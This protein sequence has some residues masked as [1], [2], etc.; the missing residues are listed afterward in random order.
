MYKTRKVTDL[1]LI[2]APTDTIMG[3]KLPT[4]LQVLK[5]FYYFHNTKKQSINRSAIITIDMATVFW[6]KARIPIRQKCN[7][8]KK[9]KML[10]INYDNIKKSKNRRTS[11]QINNEAKFTEQ[12]NKLFDIAHENSLEMINLQEDKD[13]LL[14]QRSG[15]KGQ[16]AGIDHN[17]TMKEIRTQHRI[18]KE[19]IRVTKNKIRQLKDQQNVDVYSSSDDTEMSVEETSVEKFPEKD[20]NITSSSHNK[21]NFKNIV[22]PQLTSALDRAKVTDRQAV[23]VV[24]AT[25]SSLGNNID[26]FTLSRSSIRRSRINHRQTIAIEN[27]TK[28]YLSNDPVI[29]HWDGKLLPELTGKG[30]CDRLPILISGL[31]IE[32]LLSVPKIENGTGQKMSNAIIEAIQEWKISDNVCGMSFDTTASNTGRTSGACVLLEQQI[33]KHLLNFACR[34]HIFEIILENVF[35]ITMGVSSGPDIQIF[36]RFQKCWDKIDTSMLKTGVNDDTFKS[37]LPDNTLDEVL[38]F[39]MHHLTQLHP[40]EDYRELLNL[41]VIFLGGTPPGGIRLRAPAGLHRARWMAR[42]LYSFKI[43]MF[44]R[45]KNEIGT[46]KITKQEE[47]GIRE[48]L[49]F[50]I[51]GGYIQ[52][53]ITAPFSA[54]APKN[55]LIFL[56]KLNKYKEINK[57]VADGAIKKFLGHLW[58]LS[59]DLVGLAF[60]DENISIIEKENMVLALKTKERSKN[61]ATRACITMYQANESNLLLSNFITKRTYNFFQA[62]RLNMAFLESPPIQWKCDSNYIRALKVVNAIKVVN[63]TAERGVALISEYND[64]LT[65]DELQK[66][67]LLQVIRE[68]RKKFPNT[69]KSTVA[70]GLN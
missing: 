6:H 1:F 25:V 38:Q 18:E 52:A 46:F 45:T 40:R 24:A 22:T 4:T 12:F 60:F 39:C 17:L 35:K 29:V 50:V 58:Y 62:F 33:G 55:D 54:N 51:I 34:H 61:N 49:Y 70:E 64:K 63:D 21:L 68:H 9:L 56:L 67:Y 8:V 44:G 43:F 28:F 59:E 53:W 47:N 15:R 13:F 19:A 10:I 41:T 66:Q 69:K 42:L 11:V 7:S 37:K 57:I 26:N 23:H 16:M 14:D 3:S 5:V 65:N 2:G 32:Q 30:I 27:K 31:N 20:N 36:K 48:L